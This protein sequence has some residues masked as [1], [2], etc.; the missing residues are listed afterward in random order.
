MCMGMARCLTYKC[1]EDW[2][3][4][5]L[6]LAFGRRW[7]LHFFCTSRILSIVG[8]GSEPTLPGVHL[9]SMC[10]NS[11]LWQLVLPREDV[12]LDIL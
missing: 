3:W 8:E 11:C 1:G 6:L 2:S 5:G 10:M 7:T 12:H 4:T 9:G